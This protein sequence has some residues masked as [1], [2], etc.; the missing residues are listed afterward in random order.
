MH[1]FAVLKVTTTVVDP[2]TRKV[3]GKENRDV[4][5]CFPLDVGLDEVRTWAKAH[6]GHS[7]QLLF[8]TDVLKPGMP[9]EP[10]EHREG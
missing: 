5:K 1:V 3:V 7:C 9:K 10:H 8:E 6:N 4:T 2:E